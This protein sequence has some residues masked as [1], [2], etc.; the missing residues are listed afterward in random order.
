MASRVFVGLAAQS[1][2]DLLA[3]LTLPQYRVLVVLATRGPQ[4]LG[5]LAATLEVNPSTAS[6][7]CERLVRR[8]LIRRQ[9]SRTDRREIRLSLA[10][11]GQQ[12]YEDV[13]SRRREKLAS[14][15]AVLDEDTRSHLVAGLRSFGAAYA[16]ESK[17]REQAWSLGWS[18]TPAGSA[19]H[20]DAGGDAGEG[21]PT[22]APDEGDP[23][24]DPA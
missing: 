4:N 13:M 9:T 2:A 8:H 14:L 12:L 6:R 11:T 3:D 10:P 5:S 24:P 1:V 20:Q 16:D 17:P 21:D 18:L 7:L 23:S 19:G 15:V 22:A